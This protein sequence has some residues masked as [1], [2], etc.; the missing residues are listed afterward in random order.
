MISISK[1][2]VE[3]LEGSIGPGQ[4]RL[5]RVFIKGMG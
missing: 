3:K 4:E 5:L 1:K 2:A